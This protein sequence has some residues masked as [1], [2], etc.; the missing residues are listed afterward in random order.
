MIPNKKSK[1]KRAKMF[2]KSLKKALVE[3]ER[4]KKDDTLSWDFTVDLDRKST[5]DGIKHRQEIAK[6][7]LNG[8]DNY[9]MFSML[10]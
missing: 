7:M 10:Y 5:Q 4:E 6:E 2:L 1:S 9:D 3:D 8:V